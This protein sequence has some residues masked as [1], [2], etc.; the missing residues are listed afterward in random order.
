LTAEDA[1]DVAARGDGWWAAAHGYL[2]CGIAP[3]LCVLGQRVEAR[4]GM[5]V[6]VR[7]GGRPCGYQAASEETSRQVRRKSDWAHH[8]GRCGMGNPSLTML[9][10]RGL[11]DDGAIAPFIAESSAI[12]ASRLP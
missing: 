5:R 9:Q 4:I 10:R 8:D 2:G 12:T 3:E 7:D 6:L 1:G 11:D